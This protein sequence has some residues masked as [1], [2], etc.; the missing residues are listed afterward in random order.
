MTTLFWSTAHSPFHIFHL[1]PGQINSQ[2]EY[3]DMGQSICFENV[4]IDIF[5]KAIPNKT[6]RKHRFSP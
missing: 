2:W 1:S 6:Q 4:F 3:L 5:S